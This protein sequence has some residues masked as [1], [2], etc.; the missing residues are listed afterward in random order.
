[1]LIHDRLM[2]QLACMQPHWH[3]EQYIC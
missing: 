3:Y 1:V 2:P